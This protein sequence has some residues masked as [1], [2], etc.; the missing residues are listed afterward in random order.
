M[1]NLADYSRSYNVY[2]SVRRSI[3]E[4]RVQG[5]ARTTEQYNTAVSASSPVG[6]QT[7]GTT[8]TPVGATTS[9]FLDPMTT[10]AEMPSGAVQSL[11]PSQVEAGMTINADVLSPAEA[12]LSQGKAF[13]IQQYE[14]TA[15]GQ[16]GS[17]LISA[18][19]PT[20]FG[21]ASSLLGG[22]TVVDPYGK[23]TAV[24]GGVL[25]LV[26]EKVIGNQYEVAGKI[27]E[28]IP[29]F[30]QFY[31]GNNLV[32]IVPQSLFGQKIGYT[33]LGTVGVDPQQAIAQYAV[34]LGVDPATVD[35]GKRP[36]ETGFGTPLEGF[37]QGVGGLNSQGQFVGFNGQT[38]D[39][40][41]QGLETH[42]G[43]INTLQGPTAAINALSKANVS[44]D[45]KDAMMDAVQRGELTAKEVRD[46][47]G[48]LMGFETPLGSA[49]KT[50]TGQVVTTKE[51]LPVTSG[52]GILGVQGVLGYNPAGLPG[53]SMSR[54]DDPYG[55]GSYGESGGNDGPSEATQAA[56]SVD[57][58]PSVG[59]GDND[60]AVAKTGGFITKE[61]ATMQEGGIPPEEVPPGEAP[62]ATEAGFVGAEPEG[63]PTNETIADD[64]P[65]EVPE[66]T[67]VLNAPA[68]EF[69]G[70]E[71]VKKMILEAMEEA[72]KQGIDIE[73][74]NAT[75]PKEELVSL[76]VSKGE[77]LIP[78][79][80]ANIIGF[81]R[82]NKINN[83]GKAEVQR[84]SEEPEQMKEA[85]PKPPILAKSGGFISKTS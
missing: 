43:L 66:G 19:D 67:F 68:V 52:A 48:N 37:V 32:S 31:S 53:F 24:F 13:G 79:Q 21:L 4:R 42:I 17:S 12:A 81:D 18:L 16:L 40:G 54:A 64:V 61:R 10:F 63:I 85:A 75:I 3:R 59:V 28:G 77:V 78:P 2:D 65:M 83:R 76:V 14:N 36:G 44:V 71:D 29:G 55:L 34:M 73:Q 11:S 69:M 47:Q 8:A 72:E 50:S 23:E 56:E 51:G 45:A 57:Q 80:L 6:G 5:A 30:H 35:L 20:P 82:L 38:T 39:I 60:T 62:V 46:A 70:S 33:T 7:P 58:S 15:L 49:V 22:K 74:E 41:V 9:S 1:A 27:K 26:G 25:G 84:R